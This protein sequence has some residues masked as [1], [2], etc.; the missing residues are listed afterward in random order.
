MAFTIKKNYKDPHRAERKKAYQYLASLGIRVS[1]LDHP[2]DIFYVG[3]PADADVY[4]EYAEAITQRIE[5]IQDRLGSLQIPQE[6]HE[7]NFLAILSVNALAFSFNHKLPQG[8]EE[9][10]TNY[11][12]QLWGRS[13]LA[14][15]LKKIN[16]LPPQYRGDLVILSEVGAFDRGR[17]RQ[18]EYERATK[19]E[20][21]PGV[22][23]PEGLLRI[24]EKGAEAL[25]TAKH[26]YAYLYEK[27]DWQK[28]KGERT[29]SYDEA[30]NVGDE[31]KS[32]P[33][34][35]MLVGM[36]AEEI[37]ENI[38]RR[39]DIARVHALVE[40]LPPAMRQAVKKFSDDELM[41]PTERKSKDRGLEKVRKWI[42]TEKPSL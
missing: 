13:D 14:R 12:A 6:K 10:L 2:E 21:R 33:L 9:R 19:P 3:V 27:A 35:E 7:Q 15:L 36:T 28:R 37:L 20:K 25:N 31:G 26:L 41:D 22:G 16:A 18:K 34:R 8:T 32:L 39:A 30:P 24:I 1:P 40:K 42:S 11:L 4:D 5:K 17:F 23:T 38:D 29:K